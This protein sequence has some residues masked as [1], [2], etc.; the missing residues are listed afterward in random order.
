[1]ADLTDPTAVA[2]VF[3][4][5]TECEV[6]HAAGVIHP[7]RVR[8]FERINV[9]G[10]ANILRGAI[11]A[12]VR[13]FVHLSSNSAIGTNPG[14]A[15]AF[16]D[17][18]PFSPYLGYGRSKM[19]AEI[20]VRDML[21]DVPGVI[22]RPPWFYGRFQPARQARFLKTVRSGRFPLI[23]DGSNRR[24]MVDVDLLAQ[25]A[26]MAL[27]ADTSGVR[28]YWVADALP[29]SMV[30][31]LDAVR[32]A[33]RLEG[34]PVKQG[35]LRLPG[36]AGSVA[37]RIDEALQRRGRY[38]QEIHVAGELDKTIACRVDGAVRDLGFRPATDLVAGLRKSF[39]WGLDN[40][41]D[42]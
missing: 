3:A 15:E 5:L 40:G 14:P 39:R 25:A 20:L 26:W 18:E 42:V 2:D 32:E 4:D 35:V 7:R 31:I 22:L 16:R 9:D 37:Y 38:Q 24:S 36:L 13:R 23:G 12:G 17:N 30:E 33:A 19:R 21:G 8:D 27:T 10:T 28:S 11:R 6:V 41:Q 29:Y 1:V 34:L